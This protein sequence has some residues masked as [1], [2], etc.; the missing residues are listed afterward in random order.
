MTVPPTDQRTPLTLDDAR[1]IYRMGEEAVVQSLVALSNRVAELEQRAAKNSG[2]SSKPP[3]SDGLHRP[4]RRYAKRDRS[5]RKRGGQPG[6][7]GGT[8]RM[9]ATPDVVRRH[10]VCRCSAC[11]RSLTGVTATCEK[12]QVF[13]IPP[14]SLT[15]TEHQA[16]RKVCPYCGI[17]NRAPFPDGVPPGT[18]YGEHFQTLAIYLQHQQLLPYERTADLLEDLFGLRPSVGTLAGFQQRCAQRVRPAEDRTRELL[19][20]A[21]Q[22]LCDETGA[23]CNG[24]LHWTHTT[25]HPAL[26][27][28]WFDKSR[29]QDAMQR[30]GILPNFTGRVMHDHMP[31][32]FTFTCAHLLC[33]AHHLRELRFVAEVCDERWAEKMRTLLGKMYGAVEKAGA[34]GANCL[35]ARQRRRYHAAYRRLI[36]CGER[37]HRRLGPPVV[38]VIGKRGRKKQH[39]GKNLLDRLKH[40]EAETLGFL[41]DFT[42]PFTNNLAERDLRMVKVKMKI[43]G[44]FRSHEGAVQFF[45]IRGYLSTAR[46]QHWHVIEALATAVRGAPLIPVLSP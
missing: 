5:T 43:S 9:T 17:K 29:G 6:H 25:S 30:G 18:S 33:N 23:H 38:D 44:G 24:V 35:S 45:R 21:D 41:D 28:Y 2:N 36:A 34:R 22:V 16:E 4:A 39:P 10:R 32:Y 13:D 11:N 42:A 3:G 20:Q 7:P 8:L 12:R 46:K 27:Q 37:F 15:V 14:L 31:A 19:L 26:T 1:T 40:W